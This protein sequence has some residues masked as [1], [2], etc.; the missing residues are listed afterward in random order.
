MSGFN[1]MSSSIKV[2]TSVR[3]FRRLDGQ[4]GIVNNIINTN[5]SSLAGHTNQ[6]SGSVAFGHDA[7]HNNQGPMSVAIGHQAGM[8]DQSTG[9][10]LVGYQAGYNN[11]DPYGVFVGHKAG[12]GTV[13]FYDV[14]IGYSTLSS[15]SSGIYPNNPSSFTETLENSYNSVAIGYKAGIGTLP[16]P[17]YHSTG[18]CFIQSTGPI[19]P[20][21]GGSISI[22]SFAGSN[23][24][25]PANIAI[26]A[27]AGGGSGGFAIIETINDQSIISV[28]TG[29]FVGGQ[30]GY[31]IAIGPVAG[32]ASQGLGAIAVGVQAGYANQS[33]G[34]ISIGGGSGSINQGTDS[35]AIGVRAGRNNQGINSISIGIDAGKLDQ[36]SYSVAIGS[37]SA[38]FNQ[39]TGA[40][41]IGYKS[42]HI[43]QGAYSVAIGYQAGVDNMPSNCIV[44][45]ASNTALNSETDGLYVNPIRST[46][47]ESSVLVWDQSTK[48]ILYNSA[49]TFV[50][51]HPED[52]ESYL[53][54]ACLEGPESG[55]YYR[56]QGVIGPTEQTT[57]YLPSYVSKLASDFTIQLTPIYEGK[58][59]LKPLAASE[60][61]NG[62]FCV[63]GEPGKFYWQVMGNRHPIITEIK[64]D[65][66]RIRGNGPYKYFI[67][68]K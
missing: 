64:K 43:N 15:N 59:R 60:V 58:S 55:V 6:A 34:A 10:V 47:N 50:I 13:G 17:H 56:G 42:G 46:S 39:S 19:F 61:I 53:I 22:G 27:G 44:L 66:I 20:V 16:I 18:N 23:P 68:N 5:E 9:S 1:R 62:S 28:Q 8:N 49:K 25:G 12:I 26:G 40:V 48:E 52:S 21:L 3:H 36:E 4:I 41:A 29:P 67:P 14:G 45:N 54:H 30:G 33:S 32:V 2:N 37:N 7:G 63:F 35:I 24:S 38:Q 11:S 51:N 65:E 31:S 57:I